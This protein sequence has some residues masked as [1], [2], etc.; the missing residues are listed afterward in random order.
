MACLVGI[1]ESACRLPLPTTAYQIACR[2]RPPL[3]LRDRNSM[4]SVPG[5]SFR[6]VLTI[7]AQA[8][9]EQQRAVKAQRP[10]APKVGPGGGVWFSSKCRGGAVGWARACCQ[11]G[12]GGLAPVE[13]PAAEVT[14][15]LTY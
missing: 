11:Q 9:R 13:C 15:E 10:A 1:A 3:Q 6:K 12:G 2:R 7:L 5:R 8:Q 14:C 4:L